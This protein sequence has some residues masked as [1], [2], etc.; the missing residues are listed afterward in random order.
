MFH[1]LL[2]IMLSFEQFT[3][4]NGVFSPP[5]SKKLFLC[6]RETLCKPKAMKFTS[7]AEAQP[8]FVKH[9]TANV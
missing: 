3:D 5:L 9:C 6:S 4:F 2:T 1:D 8:M 7:M